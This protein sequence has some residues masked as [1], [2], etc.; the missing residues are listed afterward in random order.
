MLMDE[1]SC[2]PG[3]NV[4]VNNYD[5]M[6]R[7]ALHDYEEEVA[8]RAMRVLDENNLEGNFDFDHLCD[9]HKALF[10]K[11]YPW[12]GEQRMVNMLKKEKI[13][14]G[15]SLRYEDYQNIEE[16][17]NMT[18]RNMNSIQWEA[19]PRE[20][21]I[22]LLG[23]FMAATWLIHPFREGNTR[24]ISTFFCQ[25]ARSK[26]IELDRSFFEKIGQQFRDALVY[27]SAQ[28]T[29]LELGFKSDISPLKFIL[30]ESIESAERD[31]FRKQ[32]DPNKQYSLEALQNKIKA[33]KGQEH[34]LRS[35]MKR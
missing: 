31:K 9:F 2:Y 4:L 13:L 12:A 25:F 34:E 3:T 29:D 14:G 8:T 16:Y 1:M 35:N 20:Q 21:Q 10:G 27:A 23:K 5:I 6:D 17:M 15:N 19:L 28:S 7:E 18:L 33:A 30:E 11:L 32:V 22:E 24:S 26:G